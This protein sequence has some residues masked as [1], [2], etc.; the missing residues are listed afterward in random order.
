VPEAKMIDVLLKE[1]Q[2]KRIHFA[3]V[4]DE[5]GGTNGIVTMED[6]LEEIIGDI[7]DEFDEEENTVRKIDNHTYIADAKIMLYDLCRAMRLPIDTFDTVKGE[8][9]SLAGLVLEIAGEFPSINETITSGDFDFTILE[10]EKN[11][12]K[13]VQISINHE[14][15]ED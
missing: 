14:E 4:V 8:S 5:F 7:K 12:I 13:T 15:D 2:T 6:I 1:F 11:R 10:S 9:D 3:I